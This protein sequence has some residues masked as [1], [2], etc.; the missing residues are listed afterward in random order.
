MQMTLR[1]GEELLRQAAAGDE[2]A[3]E[4]LLRPHLQP[5][6]R[7]AVTLLGDPTAAEDAVQESTFKAWRHLGRLRSDTSV[8]AWFLTVVANQ[9]RSERRSRWWRVIRGLDR[10]EDGAPDVDVAGWDLERA[11]LRLGAQDRIALF[12]RFYEDLPLAGVAAVLNVSTTAA[13]SRIH[14]ALSRMRRLLE[15]EGYL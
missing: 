4:R 7:L 2:A 14:R 15:A 12:L 11:L 13:K 6:Y 1:D 5:A 3:F 8:R 9:C 10:T